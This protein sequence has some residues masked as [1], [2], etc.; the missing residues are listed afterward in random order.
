MIKDLFLLATVLGALAVACGSSENKDK[1]PPAGPR[2]NNTKTKTE[3]TTT[4]ETGSGDAKKTD[5]DE[6][7]KKGLIGTPSLTT[8]HW[9]VKDKSTNLGGCFG[10][11]KKPPQGMFPGTVKGP[12]PDTIDVG[13]K[14]AESKIIVACPV[15]KSKEPYFQ[16][17]LYENLVPPDGKQ[18]GAKPT[19]DYL[20]IKTDDSAKTI[21][22]RFESKSS[23]K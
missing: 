7:S 11:E 15:D 22:K 23:K 19:K 4:S 8:Y 6:P 12:C 13:S 18:Q 17:F 2:N 20:S 10:F 1:T 3:Q 16:P 14:K 5:K 9:I 21:C